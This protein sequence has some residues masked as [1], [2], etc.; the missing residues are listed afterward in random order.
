MLINIYL[1]FKCIR[2]SFIQQL[3]T[4]YFYVFE[5]LECVFRLDQ[6]LQTRG[7]GALTTWL[8]Q[9]AQKPG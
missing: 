6:L 1:I 7:W 9:D 5:K 8:R 3:S 4:G 2:I